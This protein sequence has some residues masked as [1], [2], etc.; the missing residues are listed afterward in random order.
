MK[1][2]IKIASLD[3]TGE[4]DV[5]P[6]RS[7]LSIKKTKDFYLEYAQL[8]AKFF[9]APTL[10]RGDLFIG[11]DSCDNLSIYQTTSRSKL[12]PYVFGRI[13]EDETEMRYL[14]N[15]SVSNCLDPNEFVLEDTETYPPT[16]IRRATVKDIEEAI[17][18]CRGV[19]EPDSPVFS[20]YKKWI[21][22]LKG[23]SK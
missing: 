2:N 15:Y 22:Q 23:V 7:F 18:Y 3:L 14:V 21:R 6:D 20:R 8:L 10:N 5:L 16:Y 9:T 11:R 17:L 12:V 4:I 19:L 13:D 1:K